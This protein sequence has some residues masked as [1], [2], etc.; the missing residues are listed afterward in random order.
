MAVRMTSSHASALQDPLE[1]EFVDLYR[2]WDLLE[3]NTGGDAVIDFDLAAARQVAQASSR[4][5]VV[6]R[7]RRL[8]DS[9]RGG[10][11]P[12][13]G[14]RELMLRRVEAS[15][16]Y[17]GALTGGT[18]EF[19]E[20]VT[21]TMGVTPTMFEEDEIRS[22]RD[23]VAKL[24]A[25]TGFGGRPLTFHSDDFYRFQNAFLVR[26]NS[27]LPNQFEY[28]KTKWVPVLCEHIDVPWSLYR[29]R[30]TF[31]DEDAY[32]KNWISG[33]LA[34]H[35]IAMRINVH[36][37]HNWYQG[38]A[39][40]LVLHEFCGHAVQMIN[41]HRRIEAGELP[42][43]AGILTVHFPDQFTIEG[44]AECVA[45]FLPTSYCRLEPKSAVLRE[46]HHYVLMVMNNL[47]IVANQEGGKAASQY[48]LERLP[49]TKK[50]TIE[51]EVRDRTSHP[52]YRTYQYIYGFA[53]RAFLEAMADLSP[54]QMWAL[55]KSVYN[56]P[57]SAQ[58]FIQ[59]SRS[60]RAE[61][62]DGAPGGECGR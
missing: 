36:R 12:G 11:T 26:K 8:A 47:H 15:L 24:V 62:A 18:P 45:H 30:V 55:L 50:E 1:R 54:R 51:A 34:E 29:I 53:K 25:D 40:T 27:A 37:R 5:E 13:D 31:A 32:W 19:L 61:V 6:E 42:E 39:E 16:A 2:A 28:Y 3:R 4:A 60:V 9:I 43:A 41:W 20:Y 48:A 49:F 35:E 38:A 22:K 58:Q 46:L 14:W 52:L 33:N 10:I 44:L 59:L 17:L 23:E 57:M 7:L 56:G 21:Q